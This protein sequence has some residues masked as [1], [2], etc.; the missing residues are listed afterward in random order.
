MKKN[1]APIIL[2]T[3]R[4]LNTLKK[5]I[6]NLSKNDISKETEIFIFSD[7]Y[8]NKKD[9]NYVL[10]VRKYLKNINSFKKKKNFL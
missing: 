10:K 5:T 2:F 4:R 7:G 6:L 3:Y 8:K 9:K 1:Y